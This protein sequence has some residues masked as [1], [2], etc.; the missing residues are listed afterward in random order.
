M[1]IVHDSE[2]HYLFQNILDALEQ[3][4]I[5]SSLFLRR[6]GFLLCTC[7][8]EI[9]YDSKSIIHT[10][11]SLYQWFEAA[12]IDT[13][14]QQVAL[15]RLAYFKPIVEEF[16]Q[17]GNLDSGT[18]ITFLNLLKD[19]DS[20]NYSKL[21]QI[22]TQSDN[23]INKV[24]P[25]MFFTKLVRLKFDLKLCSAKEFC[26][27]INK[28]DNCAIKYIQITNKC[29]IVIRDTQHLLIRHFMGEI[30]ATIEATNDKYLFRAELSLKRLADAVHYRLAKG[31]PTC[32]TIIDGN[33]FSNLRVLL[34]SPPSLIGTPNDSGTDFNSTLSTSVV[35][36]PFY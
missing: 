28:I 7:R 27:L 33:S 1:C 36:T 11:R 19:L 4:K 8:N 13:E 26:D 29:R 2:I 25:G 24:R 18:K 14:K 10:Q 20:F 22:S 34:Q 6:V 21:R 23:K 32:E 3:S 12:L 5:V 15:E 30:D 9:Y 17:N 31:L 35:L 16:K